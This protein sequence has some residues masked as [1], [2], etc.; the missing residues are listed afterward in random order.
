MEYFP[1][2]PESMLTGDNSQTH[3]LEA[4]SFEVLG[5]YFPYWSCSLSTSFARYCLEEGY[6]KY[7]TE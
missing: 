1:L 5:P 7:A 6:T 3:G 2:S 4:F